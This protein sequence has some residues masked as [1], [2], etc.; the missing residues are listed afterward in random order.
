MNIFILDLDHVKCAEYHVDRHNIKMITELAQ[1]LS[2]AHRLLDGELYIGLSQSGCKVKR[3]KL[4]D[5]TRDSVIYSATHANHPC[6][7]WVRESKENYE[8]TNALLVA[9]C[10][11]YTYRYNKTHKTF[12]TELGPLLSTPPVNIPSIGLTPFAQAMPDEHKKSDA[13]LAYR[14]YY[15]KA[16]S[17]LHTWKNRPPRRGYKLVCVLKGFQIHS[18]NYERRLAPLFLLEQE[19]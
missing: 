4:N 1:L 5:S 18:Q 9:L 10:S 2:T 14:E 17:H 6:A 8:W 13:V 16:K 15:R 12:R 3:W 7:V 11:E 19:R